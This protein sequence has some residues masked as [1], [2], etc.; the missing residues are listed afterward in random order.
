MTT[1]DGKMYSF[2][3]TAPQADYPASK[4]YFDEMANTF[5]LTS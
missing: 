4:K 3:L 5:K 2:F 1:A